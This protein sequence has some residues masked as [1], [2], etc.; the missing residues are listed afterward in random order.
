MPIEGGFRS[1]GRSSRVVR[2]PVPPAGGGD[3]REVSW[4]LDCNG[5][6]LSCLTERIVIG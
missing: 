6:R 3:W 1:P 4:F 2:V 5:T